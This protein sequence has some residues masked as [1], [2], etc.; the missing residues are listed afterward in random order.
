MIITIGRMIANS[1]ALMDTK[2][3]LFMLA[4]TSFL[5][6]YMNKIC[7]AFTQISQIHNYFTII[8]YNIPYI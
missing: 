3:F 2:F 4:L 5:K 6:R 1:F 8:S 7:G